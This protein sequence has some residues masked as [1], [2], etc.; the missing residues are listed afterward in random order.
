M[1]SGKGK[2][3]GQFLAGVM[4]LIMTVVLAG[5]ARAA[6]NMPVF[7]GETV[8]GLG[9]FDSSSLQGKVVLVNF[10]ATWCPPCRKEIPS[11]AKLQEIYRAKGLVVVGVSMDDG[12]RTMVG[13][14]LEKQGVHYPVILGDSS[15]AKGFGGVIGVPASFLVNRKG[16][17]VRRF[18]GYASEDELRDELEKL[19]N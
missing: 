5:P 3:G 6:K 16:E 1:R 19:L 15:V 14:F 17:L 10:W 8:N 4:L 9:K 13:K 7:S 12:G 2:M 11:L 18:D